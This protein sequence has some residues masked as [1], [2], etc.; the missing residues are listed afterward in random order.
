[1]DYSGGSE[2]SL[3]GGVEI[4]QLRT[5]AEAV[6]TGTV[7]IKILDI[8]RNDVTFSCLF[9]KSNVWCCYVAMLETEHL[10]FVKQNYHMAGYNSFE[11]CLI[12][13]IPD[14]SHDSMRQFLEPQE[15]YKWEY[16]NYSTSYTMCAKVVD[17]NNGA[18]LVMVE[19]FT[20][21]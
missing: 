4:V 8:G 13:M 11:E 2:T 12:S 15:S 5:N 21:K 17:M 10:E 9:D 20:T 3:L 6:G 14:L 7:D 18:T 16:L 1:M 19:P